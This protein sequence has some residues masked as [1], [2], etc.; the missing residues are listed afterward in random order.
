MQKIFNP[1]VNFYKYQIKNFA[2]KSIYA[3]DKKLNSLGINNTNTIDI[4]KYNQDLNKNN[5]L[6][7]K[8]LEK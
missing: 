2:K 5:K 1:R 4:T 8:N 6:E 7:L 3:N